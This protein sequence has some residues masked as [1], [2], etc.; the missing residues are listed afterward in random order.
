MW[1][2]VLQQHR[3]FLLLLHVIRCAGP[4]LS[5]KLKGTQSSA[6]MRIRYRFKANLN[7]TEIRSIP[8]LT[9]YDKTTL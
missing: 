2:G 7:I 3:S 6:H 5:P 9:K 8:F 4:T 1:K